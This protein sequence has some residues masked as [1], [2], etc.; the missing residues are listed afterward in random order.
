M[1]FQVSQPTGNSE[2]VVH[3]HF[4]LGKAFEN[5][6]AFERSFEH[7][8]QGNQIKRDLV[9]Y[10]SEVMANNFSLQKKFFTPSQ[11]NRLHDIGDPTRDPIFILGLPRTGSTLV[12]QILSSHSQIDG[13]LETAQYTG[14]CPGT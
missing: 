14:L 11:V 9:N 5:Q 6:Q 3:L 8:R 7:Y 1:L 2:D 12:E 13:T 4:A 10:D